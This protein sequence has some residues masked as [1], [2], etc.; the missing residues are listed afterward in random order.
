MRW[1]EILCRTQ[2]IQLL[3]FASSPLASERYDNP[4]YW[5]GTSHVPHL[6]WQ[7]LLVGG[8]GASRY[9]QQRIKAELGA[10]PFA[11]GSRGAASAGTAGPAKTKGRLIKPRLVEVAHP[12]AAV[13]E[14]RVSCW[15]ERQ[16]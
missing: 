1:D 9:L 7:V 8:F 15:H 4:T 12:A 16:C 2:T 6:T 11:A 10:G 14:G 5:Y 3:L 13:V